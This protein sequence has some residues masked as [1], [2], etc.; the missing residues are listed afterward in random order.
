MAGITK[1]ISIVNGGVGVAGIL[2]GFGFD[3]VAITIGINDR[4]HLRGLT[5][6]GIGSGSSGIRFNG[7]GDLAIENC[8]IRDFIEGITISPSISPPPLR[9][10]SFSVSNTI[11]S[12][13]AGLGISISPTGGA[14]VTG[15]LSKVITNSN[16]EGILVEGSFLSTPSTAAPSIQVTIVDSEASN[17]VSGVN[18]ITGFDQSAATVAVM[19]RNVVAS[20]NGTGLEVDLNCVLWVA[21]S[22]VT[23]NR[24]FGVSGGG[25]LFSYGD[26]DID[27]NTTDNT[28]VLTPLAKH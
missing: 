17:N 5:I 15:V 23:G 25:K 24:F 18:V 13:N 22:V 4:V 20:N 19:V 10:S 7:G 28:G 6:E 2:A 12:N 21:H 27:G 16:S 8:V 14:V 26:N 9:V 1:S 3:G 11:A